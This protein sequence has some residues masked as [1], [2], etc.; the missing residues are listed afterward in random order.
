[1]DTQTF[2][3]LKTYLK[4]SS[5]L[6][7]DEAKIY[8]LESRLMPLVQ[9][10]KLSSIDELAHKVGAGVDQ[11]ILQSVMEAMTTNETS[12]MRDMKPFQRFEKIILPYLMEKRAEQKKLRIWCAAC[13]SGQEP[14]T[15]AML[16][17]ERQAKLTDWSIDIVASDISQKIVDKARAGI[18]TQFEV[19]RGLPVTML[20]KY[21]KQEGENWH[22]ND[23]IKKMV[24]YQTTNLLEPFTMLGK[25]D[26]I[27][28]RNVLIYF[29]KPDKSDVM[30]RLA[31]STADD[32]FLMLGAAETVLGLSDAW[33]PLKTTQGLYVPQS[34]DTIDMEE[35]YAAVV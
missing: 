6:I 4:K 24:R 7:I 9:E 35:K 15:L 30:N 21:F 25:F 11:N 32:G 23:D 31:K 34:L 14:Y 18:Y 1:M 22:I 20:V 2:E 12:F 33:K 13:S 29:D 19:Q 3:I 17:K 5:G 10:F 27:L 26:L 16:L 28:C 8:L